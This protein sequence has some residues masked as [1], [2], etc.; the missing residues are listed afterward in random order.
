MYQAT[1]ARLKN[2]SKSEHYKLKERKSSIAL[3]APSFH[4]LHKCISDWKISVIL[5]IEAKS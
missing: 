1:N 3:S 5:P 4:P 2:D